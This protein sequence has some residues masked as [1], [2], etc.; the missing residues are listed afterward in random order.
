MKPILLIS[1]LFVIQ[2][3]SAQNFPNSASLST[4][5]GAIGT[6]DP[7]WTTSQLFAGVPPLPTDPTMVYGPAEIQNNCAP[8]AW[9]DPAAL[10]PPINNGNWITALGNG[11]C[12]GVAGYTYYRLT[13]NL[14]AACGNNP[15]TVAGNYVINFDGYVDNGITAVYINGNDEGVT[16]GGSFAAGAQK[17][18]ILDG[19]W[20]AGINYVDILVYNGGGPGGLLLVA[21]TAAPSATLDD[22]GDGVTNIN[23]NC[24]CTAGNDNAGCTTPPNNCN[25]SLIRNTLI[26]AGNAELLGM[27][28]SC[29]I[30]FI[31]TQTMTGPNA[32][33]YAQTFG[34]NL[35][36]VQS[37]T[38]NNGVRAALANQGYAGNVIWLGFSDA[39]NEGNYVWYDGSPVTY[40]NWNAGEPNGATGENCTQIYPNGTW[41][42]LNCNG[43]NSMSVIEVSLCPQVAVITD[44]PTHCIGDNIMLVASTILGSP[45]YSYTWTQTGTATITY[46][47]KT[48]NNDTVLVNSVVPNTFTVT[49][50]DRYGCTGA[51]VI[52][53]TP[54]PPPVLALTP[55]MIDCFGAA[56]GAITVTPTGGV[57]PYAY[58]WNNLAI[59][60]TITGL[61]PATYGVQVTDANGCIQLDTITITQP[62][63]I[64]ANFTLNGADTAKICIGATVNFDA[65]TSTG[66]APITYAWTFHDATTATGITTTNAYS[67]PGVFYVQLSIKDGNNCTSTTIRK[68]VQIADIPSFTGTHANRT[69]ICEGDTTMLTG[70]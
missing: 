64:N 26:A 70:V 20:V 42:D 69:T 2:S 56:N 30:Y 58:L 35:I 52:T 7:I 34:A 25:T 6:N 33:A 38:E 4:G 10:P 8:G 15:V 44:K 3:A 1:L 9:V 53:T 67:A 31:N 11:P 57:A 61:A 43:Y 21:N 23:D 62:A 60:A 51:N 45:N 36:S 14:P 32:Q 17:N 59:T 49:S 29:S 65:S 22:D 63:Q 46:I 68:Q 5:Q 19:P 47:D 27:D 16:P 48:G 50:T 13:L 55:T 41:N 39:V 66:I 40:T 37:V 54:N 12:S 18:I 28:N 24:P